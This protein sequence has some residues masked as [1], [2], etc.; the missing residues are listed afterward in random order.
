MHVTAHL[1]SQGTV[2]TSEM[3]EALAAQLF[4]TIDVDSDGRIVAAEWVR[5][6]TASQEQQQ[7]GR[8]DQPLDVKAA[9]TPQESEPTAQ[10]AVTPPPAAARAADASTAAEVAVADPAAAAPTAADPNPTAAAAAPAAATIAVAEAVA[11]PAPAAAP[12]ASSS[13]AQRLTSLFSTYDVNGDGRLSFE[14]LSTAYAPA[15]PTPALSRSKGYSHGPTAM[16][17]RHLLYT[18]AWTLARTHKA[19]T[20][21]DLPTPTCQPSLPR[22]LC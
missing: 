3:A 11:V 9:Q 13:P 2:P 1:V 19:C 21:H 14:E 12:D 16:G 5:A 7:A 17:Q 8:G 10:P 15:P 4:K 18:P 22:P 20:W 6:Y